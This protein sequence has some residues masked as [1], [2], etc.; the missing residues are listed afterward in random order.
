MD[1]NGENRK[2]NWE[3]TTGTGN[4]ICPT[5]F[6][7]PTSTEWDNEVINVDRSTFENTFKIPYS[8]YRGWSNGSSVAKGSYTKL[9][10]SVPLL[11]GSRSLTFSDVYLGT[12]NYDYYDWR[13]NGIN[14]RCIKE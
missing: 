8:G 7:V 1:I 5:G 14:V 11:K 9:W 6:R 12:G 3:L 10:T 2:N 13:V 4:A